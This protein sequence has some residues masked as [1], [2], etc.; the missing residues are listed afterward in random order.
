MGVHQYGDALHDWPDNINMNMYKYS[1]RCMFIIQ[2]IPPS[3]I[4]MN[5]KLRQYITSSIKSKYYNSIVTHVKYI[6]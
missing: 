4:S 5:T 1:F 6:S 3:P 2:E